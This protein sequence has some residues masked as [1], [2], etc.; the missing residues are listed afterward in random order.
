MIGSYKR[1][2]LSFLAE[3]LNIRIET[4][5]RYLIELIFRNKVKG[6][7]NS[8]QGYFENEEL[9]VSSNEQKTLSSINAWTKKLKKC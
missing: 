2:K 1:I 8:L 7:I 9:M 3:A 6:K 4:A 5:E